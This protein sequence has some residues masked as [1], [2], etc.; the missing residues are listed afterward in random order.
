[1]PN[2][3]SAEHFSKEAKM[4]EGKCHVEIVYCVV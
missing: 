3:I 1:M 2:I 4:A